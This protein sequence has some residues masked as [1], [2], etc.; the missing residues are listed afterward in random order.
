MSIDH[1]V[2]LAKAG[3]HIGGRW[4]SLVFFARR[5]PLGAGGAVI[6]AMFVLMA[7]FADAITLFDP[8]ATNPRASLARPGPV[9]WLGADFMGRDMF[10]RIVYGARISLAVGL[11]ATALGCLV[12][13][14]IGL[15]SGY[16]GG[17]V[18]LL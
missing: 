16:L 9:H 3:A 18:D 2:E 7:V 11:G 17:W 4:G 8:T 15:M 13:V 10:S 6:V 12:G 14:S 5:Y 1:Q